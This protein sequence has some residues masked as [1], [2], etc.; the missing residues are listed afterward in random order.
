MF[1][2]QVENIGNELKDAFKKQIKNYTW[3]DS[4]TQEY[5]SSKMDNIKMNLAYPNWILTEEFEELHSYLSDVSVIKDRLIE[6]V[7]QLRTLQFK[8]QFD[9][10]L[11]PSEQSKMFVLKICLS[12]G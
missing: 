4:G 7:L 12:F 3:M 11:K 9:E 8:H 10:F 6:S 1:F 2:S 5:A